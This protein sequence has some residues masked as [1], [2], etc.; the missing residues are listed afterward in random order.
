MTPDG[1]IGRGRVAVVI[2]AAM[3]VAADLGTK[4]ARA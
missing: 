1:G 3:A 4:D 2:A